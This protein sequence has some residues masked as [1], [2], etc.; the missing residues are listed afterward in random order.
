[1]TCFATPD[2]TASDRAVP[3][4]RW[5]R[6]VRG[7]LI[8]LVLMALPAM[9]AAAEFT[10]AP[11][12][13]HLQ[14]GHA[15]ETLVLGNAQDSEIGFEVA[16]KR[17]TQ[18]EDGEWVLTPDDGLIVHPLIVTLPASGKTRFRVG[19]LS[20][21]TDREQAYR[22]E[23]QQLPAARPAAGATVQLLTR[24]SIP[25]FV[26]PAQIRKDAA[27][28][29]PQVESGAVRVDLVNAGETYLAPQDGRLRLFDAGGRV[30]LDESLAVGYV[31]AGATMPLA[32][33][34]AAGV[35]ARVRRIELRLEADALQASVAVTADARRCGS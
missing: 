14:P 28:A 27:L 23:L 21:Q 1:M 22:I 8:A 30:L 2:A 16:V 15:S 3:G 34:L 33:P 5:M 18:G 9:A 13:V 32:R 24:M 29:R 4:L 7:V 25:V 10:L 19:T 12:R 11:T 31:L 6:I 20:P 17:W 26:Q 35:C